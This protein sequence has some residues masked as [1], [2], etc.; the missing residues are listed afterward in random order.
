MTRGLLV[1]RGG[2]SRGDC[3]EQQHLPGASGWFLEVQE[4]HLNPEC[5]DAQEDPAEGRQQLLVR[6]LRMFT[7]VHSKTVGFKE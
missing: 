6:I 5:R 4:H 3:G 2:T 1:V 7:I